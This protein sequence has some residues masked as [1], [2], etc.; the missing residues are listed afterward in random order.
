MSRYLPAPDLRAAASPRG[1]A[2]F[3]PAH[4]LAH[5]PAG[6]RDAV[7]RARAA[8]FAASFADRA[9]SEAG[10]AEVARLTATPGARTRFEG[11]LA[12]LGRPALDRLAE[13]TGYSDAG[14]QD[15]EEA[16]Q[17]LARLMR[18]A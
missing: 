15:R 4:A 14:E 1:R 3:D 8:N 16:R 17:L 7:L 13:Q 10:R 12:A 6:V 5:L 9:S 18:R 2:A 11:A